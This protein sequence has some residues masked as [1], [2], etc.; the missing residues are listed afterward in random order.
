LGA[1]EILIKRTNKAELYRLSD[2]S[3]LKQYTAEKN[4]MTTIMQD[5]YSLLSIEQYF[6]EVHYEGWLY[7][8]VKFL[9]LVPER[10]AICMEFVPGSA[11]SEIPK[12]KINKAEYHCGV[13][14]AL[15]HNKVFDGTTQGLVY[16][17]FTVN[18]II[19]DFEQQRVIA[20]DP[21]WAWGR[22]DY[23][24]RDLIRHILSILLTLVV[25][26]KATFST[27]MSFLR[28]YV[29]VTKVKFNFAHYYKGLYLE[30]VLRGNYFAARSLV[31]LLSFILITAVLSPFY[32]FV[33]PG[34][35]FFKGP[36]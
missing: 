3:V 25:R 16:T 4:A 2:G 7:R 17:D 29:S 34:Y 24:Y 19:L 1:E 13:W 15:Y 20:L 36:H 31:K 28:G 5:Q 23:L 27:I 32:L 12:T 30:M 8:A 22:I 6:G 21:G 18:N 9:R 33:V 26:R 14:L 10:E 11:L 35:M